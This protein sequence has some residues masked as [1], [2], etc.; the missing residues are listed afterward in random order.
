MVEGLYR[1]LA[2]DL[3][4]AYKGIS[5]QHTDVHACCHRDMLVAIDDTGRD[6][7][8]SIKQ[9]KAHSKAQAGH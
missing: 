4:C 2:N 5:A 9:C 1:D 3:I 8:M 6:T 7:C